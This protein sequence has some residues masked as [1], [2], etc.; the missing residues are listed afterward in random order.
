[1]SCGTDVTFTGEDQIGIYDSSAWA[2]RGFCKSCGSTL[3][4]RFKSNGQHMMSVALFG[5]LPGLKFT[6]Q[7]FVDERPDYYEFANETADMTGPEVFEKYR[8]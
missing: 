6:R 4:Y 7:V 3:F 5:D 8:S 2:E 1:M